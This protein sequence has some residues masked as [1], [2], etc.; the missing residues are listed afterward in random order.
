MTSIG[1]V[2]VGVINLNNKVEY[3]FI[4]KSIKFYVWE[5]LFIYQKNYK[6]VF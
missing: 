6:S 4:L 3:H 2:H 5:N 1:H